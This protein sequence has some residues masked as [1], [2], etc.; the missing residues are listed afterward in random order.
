M[1]CY[2]ITVITTIIQDEI[3]YDNLIGNQHILWNHSWEVILQPIIFI[4]FNTDVEY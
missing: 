2:V 3:V 4:G 1:L